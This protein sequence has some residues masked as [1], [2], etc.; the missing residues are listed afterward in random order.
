MPFTATNLITEASVMAGITAMGETLGGDQVS[1]GLNKLNQMVD[2]WA[3]DR[4]TIYRTQRAGGFNLTAST[5]SYTIGAGA[6][7]SVARPSWIDGAGV[8]VDPSATYPVELPL[9]VLTNIEWQRVLVKTITSALPQAIWYDRTYTSSGYGT[10]Y[11]YPIPNTA[12]PDI[13]L[14]LPIAVT[15]FALVDTIAQPPGYRIALISNLAIL[16]ALGLREIPADVQ[17]LA[18]TSK[19]QIKSVNLAA[20]MNP[21]ACDPAVMSGGGAFNFYTG[22][23]R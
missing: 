11:V 10:V 20:Q 6:T 16:M 3:A 7:W 21:M 22:N 17:A 1:Y 19:G 12:T 18:I 23:I 5:A 9:Q 8:V 13:Y 2:L 14:Y 4:L 15:E